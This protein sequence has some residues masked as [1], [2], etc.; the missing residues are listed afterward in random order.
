M[1]SLRQKRELSLG[2]VWSPL[3][4]AGVAGTR[5]PVPFSWAPCRPALPAGSA[6]DQFLRT[7]NCSFLWFFL[8]TLYKAVLSPFWTPRPSLATLAPVPFV[9]KPFSAKLE[10]FSVLTASKTVFGSHLS[11]NFHTQLPTL[12]WLFWQ[13]R[14]WCLSG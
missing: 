11:P 1:T 4:S 5:Q 2:E 10:S 14:H 3:H 8:V 7:M 12:K 9:A 6:R 13:D